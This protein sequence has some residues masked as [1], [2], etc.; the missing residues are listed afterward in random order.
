MRKLDK[1]TQ[2]IQ[3]NLSQYHSS[4]NNNT[5]TNL[6]Q[7]QQSVQVI[8]SLLDTLSNATLKSNSNTATQSQAELETGLANTYMYTL[9]FGNMS[10]RACMDQLFVHA[11]KMLCVLACVVDENA[12][13]SQLTYNLSHGSASLTGVAPPPPAPLVLTTTSTTST[14][15]SPANLT[16]TSPPPTPA[17]ASS[18]TSSSPGFLKSKFSSI[19]DSKLLSK[20]Q[21]STASTSSLASTSTSSTNSKS[22]AVNTKP[23]DPNSTLPPLP[24]QPNVSLPKTTTNIYLGSF[25]NSSHY[26]KIYE[27]LKLLYN[28]YKKSP[29]LGKFIIPSLYYSILFAFIFIKAAMISLYRF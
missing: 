3:F 18:T 1:L 12:L 28:S 10:S 13:P 23:N 21:S 2:E 4:S 7:Q 27:N 22:S 24:T 5:A 14:T 19:T 8:K 29:N 17:S 6:I 15:N 26:L 9:A 25:Q 20:N 11:A 16:Q